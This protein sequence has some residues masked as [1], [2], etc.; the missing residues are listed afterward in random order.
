[1]NDNITDKGIEHLTN[2]T[3]L[4]LCTNKKITVKGIKN[5]ISLTNLRCSKYNINKEIFKNFVKKY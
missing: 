5:L 3:N 4:D 2:L 1:L